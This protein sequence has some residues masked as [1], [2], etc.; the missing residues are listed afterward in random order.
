[1]R[2][3]A[4]L[5]AGLLVC[6]SALAQD[7]KPSSSQ[8]RMTECNKMATDMK[9]AER[10]AFMKGCLKQTDKP[11]D[12]KDKM[13]FCNKEATGIKGDERKAFMKGCLSG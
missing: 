1:M 10:Q 4:V 6:G 11:A 7:K 12:Q 3:V 8:V 13:G 9:G 5:V 2:L